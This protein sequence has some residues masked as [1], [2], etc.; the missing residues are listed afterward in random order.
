MGNPLVHFEIIGTDATKVKA[1]D[2]LQAMLDHAVALGGTVVMP[3]TEIPG[4]TMLALF[5]DPD[6]NAIGLTTGTSS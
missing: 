5:A 6:G 2:D 1:F 3:A 4:V